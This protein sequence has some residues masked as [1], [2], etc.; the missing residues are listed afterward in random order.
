M[1]LDRRSVVLHANPAAVRQF[2]AVT[3]GN[4]IASR[5]A[6]L[7]WCRRSTRRCGPAP[8]VASS[9]TRRVPSE[10]WEKVVVAP[11][12][13]PGLDWFED[14]QRQLI[15]T[16]QSLTEL[17]RVDALRGDF[18]ANA[19]HELRTPLASLLGFIET[20]LGPAARR[21]QRRGR[22]SS[23]SCAAGRAHGRLIDDLL[24]LSRIEMHQ[25]CARP[26]QSTWRACC[27]KCAMAC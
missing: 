12:Q 21:R 1:V 19:S 17:K 3:N 9:C 16:F 6:I 7:N 10:T 18:I 23:A 13:R 4:P 27:A 14:E 2:P 5:C 20:L 26:A 24:S 22:N 25:H 11:L 15:I 8:R